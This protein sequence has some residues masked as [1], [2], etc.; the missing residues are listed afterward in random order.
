MWWKKP[1][2][3]NAYWGGGMARETPARFSDAYPHTVRRTFLVREAP[4]A[5]E[6]GQRRNLPEKIVSCLWY[7]GRFSGHELVCDDGTKAE[8]VSPGW[9]NLEGGPDFHDAQI[10][11]VTPGGSRLVTGDVEIHLTA[12]DWRAHGHHTD[13][14]YD[15]VALI[16]TLYEPRR[17]PA[18][19]NSK[20]DRLRQV[21]LEKQ[22]LDLVR[23]E[24][25]RIDPDDYPYS[26][27]DNVGHCCLTLAQSGTERIKQVLDLAGDWRMV[28]KSESFAEMI[29]GDGLD[30]TYYAGIMRALGYKSFKREFGELA[31]RAPYALLREL[32]RSAGV[33]ADPVLTIQ[34][35]LFGVAGLTP[36]RLKT[37][38]DDIQPARHV[39]EIR[40]SW[41][42]LKKYFSDADSMDRAA[43]SGRAV[44]PANTPARRIA[45]AAHLL[46]RFGDVGISQKIIETVRS[47]TNKRGGTKALQDLFTVDAPGD[48]WT[49]HSKWG[50]AR[51]GR[52]LKL[53]GKS[54]A[55]AIIVN[56]VVPATL[57]H[58]RRS[59]DREL[60]TKLFEL[61]SGL[62]RLP[63]NSVTRLMTHRIFG[64][65][66]KSSE[67][68]A[69]CDTRKVLCNARRE[70]G[71]IQLFNDWCS[72]NPTCANC[73]VLPL[74]SN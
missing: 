30:Q 11:F 32:G 58:A 10:R 72:Q 59:K 62:P 36:K 47:S 52:P 6:T 35:I 34:S 68:P 23:R 71:L 64:M 55:L 48:Y 49:S 70:Q 56:A 37:E 27:P 39:R 40:S 51:L 46:A 7:E 60:E 31:S 8:V 24:A 42:Q 38:K 57:A 65:Q 45:G 12:G 26:R 63:A 16:A 4:T 54:R 1:V 5:R 14:R 17:V 13:P 43:W 3:Q 22:F 29:A 69:A 50:G 44:R 25:R 15:N 66:T 41:R 67:D 73:A 61:Y 18:A 19:K 9:W 53:I 74:L 33:A 21:F 28:A 20:G 2:W